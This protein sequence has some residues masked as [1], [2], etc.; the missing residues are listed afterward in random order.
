[1]NT[2]HVLGGDVLHAWYT[3]IFVSETIV[4]QLN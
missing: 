4:F 1:M 2:F 3:K